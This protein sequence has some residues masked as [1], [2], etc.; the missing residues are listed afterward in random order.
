MTD[1]LL[2]EARGRDRPRRTEQRCRAI[3]GAHFTGPAEQKRL[4]R[5]ADRVSL[6]PR[7]ARAPGWPAGPRRLGAAIVASGS[8]F[9]QNQSPRRL[10]A[11]RRA[12]D[13]RGAEPEA[14]QWRG[15]NRARNR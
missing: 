15:A 12:A 6:S 13:Q 1:S 4:G 8:T 3:K 9:H 2:T 5:G 11:A 7:A 10:G 14:A